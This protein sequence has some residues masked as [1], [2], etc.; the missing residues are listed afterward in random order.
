MDINKDLILP[1]NLKIE[2]VNKIDH[3]PNL[4]NFTLKECV[5]KNEFINNEIRKISVTSKY[6]QYEMM[7]NPSSSDDSEDPNLESNKND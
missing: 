7:D 3:N 1:E 2:S 6:F 4:Y 5:Q